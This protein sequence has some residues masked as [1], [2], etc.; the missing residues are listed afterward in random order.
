MKYSL[1]KLSINE[2]RVL[3]QRQYSSEYVFSPILF[4]IFGKI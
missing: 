3:I 1:K 4:Y 2:M